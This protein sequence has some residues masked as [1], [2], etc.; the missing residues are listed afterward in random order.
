MFDVLSKISVIAFMSLPEPYRVLALSMRPKRFDEIVGQKSV[1]ATLQNA[2][3]MQKVGHAYL[4]S[5]PHGT[6]K[7]TFARIFAKALNCPSPKDGGEPCNVCTS[8]LEISSCI[9]PEV[10]EIDGAS[11]R[12]IDDIRQINETV[13]FSP[14]R[15]K[16]KI[17]IIDEVHM[18]TKEA[19]NALLKT[20]ESPPPEVKFFFAT[21]EPHKV[22][23][24]VLSRCQCFDLRPVPTEEVKKF[25]LQASKKQAF[26]MEESSAE[27]IAER[28]NGSLRDALVLTDQLFSYTRGHITEKDTNRFLGLTDPETLLSFDHRAAQGSLSAAFELVKQILEKGKNISFFLDQ[29]AEH[30]EKLLHIKIYSAGDPPP[31]FPERAVENYR[32][33]AALYT[34]DQCLYILDLILGKR[35]SLKYMTSKRIFL[36]TLLIR[37][38]R[39]FRRID[40]EK[41]LRHL[42]SIAA[43]KTPSSPPVAAEKK[44][45]KN[46]PSR[47]DTLLQFAAVELE[48]SLQKGVPRHGNG[49]Q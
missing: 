25:L 9:S 17:Y 7:T 33:S 5:G 16:Y 37:I 14:G 20:L 28:T 40:P 39:S 47:Y 46:H 2:I 21:T 43:E 42:D 44:D 11:N 26:S 10:I 29:L 36:E 18:L 41:L 38:V 23:A 4:F 15:E 49:I 6:G 48:G 24:T 3:A 30:Y 35:G 13:G 8:C 12:G 32:S 1:A 19:F 45:A 27:I 31:S 34:Y 22:P